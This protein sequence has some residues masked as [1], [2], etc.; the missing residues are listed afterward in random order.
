M[1]KMIISI[2]IGLFPILIFIALVRYGNGHGSTNIYDLWLYV[3]ST[4]SFSFETLISN[5]GSVSGLINNLTWDFPQ[6]ADSNF[7]TQVFEVLKYI[8]TFFS[9]IGI[10]IGCFVAYQVLIV[11]FFFRIIVNIFQIFGFVL[12]FTG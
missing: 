12:G 7:F 5:F 3:K 2:F 4:F 9:N 1:K 10:T 8:A 11:G 6:L